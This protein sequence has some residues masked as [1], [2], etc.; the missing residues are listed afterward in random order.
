M[1][2]AATA[3]AT[4]PSTVAKASGALLGPHISR[5]K[6]ITNVL[7]IYANRQPHP[8]AVTCCEVITEIGG[9]GTVGYKIH[10]AK[11]ELCISA[12]IAGNSGRPG[13]SVGGFEGLIQR[14][15]HSRH[16]TQEEDMVSN[17]LLTQ[18]PARTDRA[19]A[20][21]VTLCRRWG[22]APK[23]RGPM[24]IQGVDYTAAINPLHYGDA[25]T[26]LNTRVSAKSARGFHTNQTFPAHL[27]F[28][29]GP[30]AGAH[31]SI[32]GSM[33]RTL[34]KHTSKNYTLFYECVQEAVRC[35]LDAM[36]ALKT[37]VA[38]LA[39]ISCGIYAGPH[40]R[41]IFNEFPELVEEI[42]REKVTD[43]HSRGHF[44]H[45]VIIPMLP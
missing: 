11:P 31:G 13:G 28:V 7:K 24:T 40:R 35:G 6:G 26:V 30:N 1:A 25:W 36:A 22:F 4:A 3:T 38:L 34:N 32:N 8:R 37:D 42:L 45:R 33:T 44:F 20:F 17:W 5:R 10:S 2:S 12:L 19:K 43:T 39:L 29:A 16:R 41:R 27:V 15:V 9:C 21:N 23:S 14:S 18:Y